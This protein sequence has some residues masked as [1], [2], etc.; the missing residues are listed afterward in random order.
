MFSFRKERR[1]KM[2]FG[3]SRKKEFMF[4]L[5]KCFPSEICFFFLKCFQN[6]PFLSD[7]MVMD[8]CNGS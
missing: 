1:N 4:I 8:V 6:K 3:L 7:K 5:G 2:V